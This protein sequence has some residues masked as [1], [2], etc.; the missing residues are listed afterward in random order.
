MYAETSRCSGMQGTGADMHPTLCILAGA[1]ICQQ[2]YA[3]CP[4]QNVLPQRRA[5]LTVS[6][7]RSHAR[8]QM[9]A[10][11]VVV[12]RQYLHMNTHAS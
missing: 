9:Y 7:H 1:R 3:M 6:L 4:L 10:G 5:F 8:L 2:L 12:L 11:N